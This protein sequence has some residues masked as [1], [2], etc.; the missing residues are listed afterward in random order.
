MTK[1]VLGANSQ[2]VELTRKVDKSILSGLHVK[3]GSYE[4]D[5]TGTCTDAPA[6]I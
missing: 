5:L 3:F 6:C 4:L 2:R 1:K